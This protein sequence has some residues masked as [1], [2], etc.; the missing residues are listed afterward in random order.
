M[1]NR[2]I[3]GMLLVSAI[4]LVFI[5]LQGRANAITPVE[6]LVQKQQGK[7]V[8]IPKDQVCMVNDAFMGSSQI[9]VPV[10]GKM[11]YGCCKMCVGKL[12]NSEEIR[13]AEDPFT[14][15]QI[16]KATAFIVLNPDSDQ[17]RVLYF[18]SEMNYKNYIKDRT[19]IE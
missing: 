16:D 1:K 15:E 12:N 4:V 8:E 14:K 7:T 9:E 3:K 10:N 13:M 5:V 18:K 6:Q 2:I 19:V 11:Y 17:K